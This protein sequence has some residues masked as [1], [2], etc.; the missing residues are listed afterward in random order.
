MT[1]RTSLFGGAAIGALIAC[2]LVPAAAH[3][4]TTKHHHAVKVKVVRV[5]D[6]TVKS[7][8]EE[9]KSEVASLEAWKQQEEAGKAQTQAQVQDLQGQ[10]A[11]ANERAQRAEAKVAEEIQTIPGEVASEAAKHAPKTDKIYY[12]GVTITLGGFAAAEA[13]YRTK[14]DVADI[15]SNYSKIP[16]TTTCWR[17]R[18]KSAGPHVRAGS[19]SWPRAM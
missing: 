5:E 6:P 14:N 13:V 10:V 12:K 17:T 4:A 15:G 9:L 3:A 11:N 8:V 19:R 7:E 1:I 2:A 16:T 18:T